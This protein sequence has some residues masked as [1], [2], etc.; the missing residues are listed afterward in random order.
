MLTI[1]L[2]A[3]PQQ[4]LN[5]TLDSQAVTL[6]LYTLTN[7]FESNLYLDVFLSGTPILTCIRCRNLSS[8]L[9]ATQ[10]TAFVGSFTFFDTQGDSDPAYA[11][12]GSRW[13]LIYLEAA[14]L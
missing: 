7:Q 5:A 6:N 12:L 2:A 4:S 8:L 9:S 1:P 13:L 10:Y 11:G 14:D 3:V